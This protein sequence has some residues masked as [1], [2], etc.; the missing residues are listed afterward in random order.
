MKLTS[1]LVIRHI[2][3][4]KEDCD[5]ERPSNGTRC[6]DGEVSDMYNLDMYSQDAPW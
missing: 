2:Y 4:M 1:K 3:L 6:C 5:K